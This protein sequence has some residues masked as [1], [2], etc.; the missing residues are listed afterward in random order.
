MTRQGYVPL[1]HRLLEVKHLYK[2][3]ENQIK[4]AKMVLMNE[5]DKRTNILLEQLEV[6]KAFD[7]LGNQTK[8][9][10]IPVPV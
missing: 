3:V 4:M 8:L 2:K 7:T 10:L 6:S 5:I 9:N 1:T